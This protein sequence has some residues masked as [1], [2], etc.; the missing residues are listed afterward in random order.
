MAFYRWASWLY[1]LVATL[2]FPLMTLDLAG[3]IEATELWVGLGISAMPLMIIQTVALHRVLQL[4]APEQRVKALLYWAVALHVVAVLLLVGAAALFYWSGWQEAMWTLL[5]GTL[6]L[7]A[8]SVGSGVVALLLGLQLLKC[9]H[10]LFGLQRTLALSLIICGGLELANLFLMFTLPFYLV[11]ALAVVYLYAWVI[12][13]H[14]RQQTPEFSTGTVLFSYG[15][16]TVAMF[17][18][19]MVALVFG[20][21]YLLQFLKLL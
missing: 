7:L 3:V 8:I 4:Y 18:L 6:P 5:I 21:N 14:A 20:I 19:P 17:V 1:V 11:C 10:P 2:L 15:M 16:A 9:P 13:G 12:E